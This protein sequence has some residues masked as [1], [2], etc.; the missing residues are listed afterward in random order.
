MAVYVHA[1]THCCFIFHFISFLITP[2]TGSHFKGLELRILYFKEEGFL[3][4]KLKL[5]IDNYDKI[6]I[7]VTGY[8]GL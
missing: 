7:F 4:Y 2:V 8:A 3:L 5:K 1:Q 6:N